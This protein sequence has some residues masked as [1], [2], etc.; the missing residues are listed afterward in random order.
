VRDLIK[1]QHRAIPRLA[2]ER[3]WVTCVTPNDCAAYPRLQAAHGNIVRVDTCS[4]GST[5]V[6]EINGSA[7]NYAPWSDQRAWMGNPE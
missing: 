2:K 1:H 7:K 3:G 5:R 4:C 6:A